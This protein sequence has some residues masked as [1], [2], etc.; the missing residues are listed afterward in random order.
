MTTICV[1]F[2]VD[3]SNKTKKFQTENNK[4]GFSNDGMIPTTFDQLP[5]TF[6][7]DFI[8]AKTSHS[9]STR[10]SA[11]DHLRIPL[12]KTNRLQQSIK[13][14]GPKIWN[15]IPL[16]VGKTSYTKFKKEYKTYLLNTT[17]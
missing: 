11:S 9:Q 15:S 16:I 5:T 14:V 6:D 1:A 13:F 10:Y 4:E 8:L 12:Y 3:K 2:E 7:Q 17:E